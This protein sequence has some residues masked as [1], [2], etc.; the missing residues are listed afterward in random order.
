MLENYKEEKQDDKKN[1]NNIISTLQGG[2]EK[3]KPQVSEVAIHTMP[4]RFINSMP[5][6][7]KKSRGIGLF[8]LLAGAVI[9]V[10]S[11]G[12]A[13]F[14]F[15]NKDSNSEQLENNQQ[16]VSDNNVNEE[17]SNEQKKINE[18]AKSSNLVESENKKNTLEENEKKVVNKATSTVAKTST[19]AT[20]T[21]KK[22]VVEAATSTPLEPEVM[23]ASDRDD[24][25]L[26]D[27]EEALLGCSSNMNDSDGDGYKDLAELF[28]LYN[29]AG[30]GE[31]ILNPNIEQYSNPTYNYFLYYPKIW[32]VDDAIGDESVLFKVGSEQFIQIILQANSKQ[33]SLE[34]WYKEQFSVPF[35]KSSQQIY[36]KGWPGI[37]HEGSPVIYLLSPKSDYIFTVSL[38]LDS[39]FSVNYKNIF[40]MMLNSLE[41]NS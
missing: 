17:E 1:V 7:N 12:L 38:N 2:E 37:M 22:I 16:Q 13:Y 40:D 26:S 14:Y 6:K 11:V 3:N 36:K 25:G 20:S 35:V 39:S 41:I 15:F 27:I 5:T 18:E 32:L 8:I 33:Q 19:K 21:P 31:I 10:V 9:L 29:P 30:E 34:E 28:N 23:V 4:K 24:D